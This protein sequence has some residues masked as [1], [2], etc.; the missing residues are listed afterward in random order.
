MIDSG[1]G[2]S[3][4]CTSL[5]TQLKLRASHTEK[6]IIEQ[7][8]GTVSRQVEICQVT[9]SFEVVDDF[10]LDLSCISGEKEVMTFLP[11]PRIRALKQRYGRFRCLKF[12]DEN[13]KEDKQPIHIILGASD[14]QRIITTQPLVSGPNPNSDP[15]AEFTMLGWTLTGKTVGKGAEAG[16]GLF[17]NST[18][19]EFERMCS[20]KCLDCLMKV[21][22]MKDSMG[23]SRTPSSAWMK[24]AI[25]QGYP[26][27]QTIVPCRQTRIL[28]WP[29]YMA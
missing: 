26:G 19:D 8:Y 5:L 2:S 9:I 21:V 16:K 14:F 10:E 28:H 27:N 23:V 12:S 1:S 11:N 29:D 17:L 25:Q 18:R 22:M 4:I 7:L 15:G 24:E 13:V 20:W 3:Y 6:R